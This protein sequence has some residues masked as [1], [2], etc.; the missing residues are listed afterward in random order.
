MI[1]ISENEYALLREHT[2][3]H[4]R[5]QFDNTGN[6]IHRSQLIEE[7]IECGM[8]DEFIQEMINDDRVESKIESSSFREQVREFQEASL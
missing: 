5:H 7:A 6:F 8:D 1:E 3:Q 4:I 2:K